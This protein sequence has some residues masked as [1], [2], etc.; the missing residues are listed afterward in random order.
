MEHH[1][2]NK[3]GH[4]HKNGGDK[5][6]NTEQKAKPNNYS[7]SIFHPTTARRAIAYGERMRK[8]IDSLSAG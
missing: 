4:S 5:I 8:R 3:H 2:A 1:R 7:E 6:I